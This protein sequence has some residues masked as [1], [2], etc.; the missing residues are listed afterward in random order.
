MQR[1][2]T[3]RCFH[4]TGPSNCQC[5]TCCGTASCSVSNFSSEE[6]CLPLHL[7]DYLVQ[8]LVPCRG[9]VFLFF[10]PI[11]HTVFG[12][13]E[14]YRKDA[15]RI[16]QRALHTCPVPTDPAGLTY[17][18][19]PHSLAIENIEDFSLPY[20]SVLALLSHISVNLLPSSCCFLRPFRSPVSSQC[21]KLL[22]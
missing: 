13:F 12:N 4:C 2:V 10:F 11:F 16:V 8:C 20:P 14:A 7:G 5:Q 6:A 18:S 17:A 3:P 21:P 15:R 9:G 1:P 19:S 22:F